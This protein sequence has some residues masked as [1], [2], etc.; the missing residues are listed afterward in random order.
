MAISKSIYGYVELLAYVLACISLFIP[1]I[2]VD[3]I[4]S[5][6]IDEYDI[7]EADISLL[8][9]LLIENGF[10][11]FTRGI[12]TSAMKNALYPTLT[13]TYIKFKSGVAVLIFIIISTI[14]VATSKFA[15]K[16]VESLKKGGNA[17]TVDTII[18]SIPFLLTLTSLIL[19]IVSG[20]S[21]S[22]RI[23]DLAIGFILLIIA[24]SIALLNRLIYIIV[25]KNLLKSNNKEINAE[26]V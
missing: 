9:E 17:K 22:C 24:L 25:D 15:K 3:T 12:K 21:V 4:Q 26:Q 16:F 20:T 10:I 8:F 19:T 6:N 1:F 5:K 23:I 18:E 2:S 13:R 7:L 11:D 14:F